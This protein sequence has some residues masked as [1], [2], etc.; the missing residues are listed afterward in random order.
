MDKATIAIA[1]GM[2][3]RIEAL[4]LLANNV[5]NSSTTGYK[6][7]K[8]FYGIYRSE[9]ALRESG[10]KGMRLP[11]I[12]ARWTDFSAGTVRETGSPAFGTCEKCPTP[13]LQN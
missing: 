7:D 2:R 3:A 8:E 6:A 11:S 4:D 1:A 5:A 12:D 9:A 10:D 13:A